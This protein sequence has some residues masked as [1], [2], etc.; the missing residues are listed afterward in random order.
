MDLGHLLTYLE[1]PRYKASTNPAT[2]E[3]GIIISR[4]SMDITYCVFEG[5]K[6]LIPVWFSSN[7]V[8]HLP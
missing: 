6:A 4:N 7:C 1:K 2:R 5:L 8:N 3:S